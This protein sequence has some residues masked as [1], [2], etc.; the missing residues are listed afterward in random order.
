MV[1]EL[2]KLIMK[3]VELQSNISIKQEKLMK[4]AC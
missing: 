2:V 3:L 1:L 4:L